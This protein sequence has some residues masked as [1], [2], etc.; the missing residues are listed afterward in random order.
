MSLLDNVARHCVMMKKT[1]VPDG[2]GGF[3]VQWNEDMEFLNYM[4]L[5]TNREYTPADKQEDAYTFSALVSKETPIG[6]NDV[7]K[8]IETGKCYRV[9]SDPD[10]KQAPQS[11]T[12]RLKFFKVERWVLT[13]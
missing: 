8:D 5:D 4:A 10:E 9:T 2:A 12:L 7:F 6:Y 11:S 1:S 3:L 13:A